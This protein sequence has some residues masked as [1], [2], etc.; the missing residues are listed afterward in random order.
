MGISIMDVA[1]F[2]PSDKALGK[3]CLPDKALALTAASAKLAGQLSPI[4]LATLEQ[5]MRVINSYYSNLIEGN[6]TRP[7]EI[8]AAQSGDYS[9]DSTKRDLQKESLAHMAVQAW[10]SE[11]NPSIDTIFSPEFILNLHQ[12]FYQRVPESL[13]M[14]KDEQGNET[15][16]VI[17]GQWRTRLVEVGRHVSPEADNLPELMGRFCETYH[18]RAYQGDRKLIAMMAAH[19]RFAWIH[20]F[21]DG[22]GRIGR[23]F[24]D[25]AL[26]AIGLD[27]YGAWCLSRGLA[28]SS[29]EYKRLLAAADAP[30][31]GNYD[32]RGALTEK[33]L[34]HFCD[35][36]LDCASDQVSYIGDLLKLADLRKRINAYV[37]A[38]N[39][40]RVPGMTESLKP[41][42]ALVLYT[43]FIHG[44]IERS[45]ALELCAMPDR[46]AR[47]LLS[48]LKK[49]GLLSEASTKSPLRWEIPE[50]A[51][52]WYFPELAPTIS[53]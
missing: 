23:L 12:Q 38:R 24:T 47:R 45:E 3:S 25:A 15:E 27:S 44:E 49:E 17:P 34:L 52:K 7:Y 18:P 43:A 53:R 20:P 1:P 4:T 42:A 14:I 19:H 10:V 51:E 11:Q 41:S 39:D 16:K 36:M 5:H 28:K 8:R 21:L 32:G 46:S 37:Q 50:H 48:Q 40:F 31:Q 33:G 26:R 30:R 6:P 22:N 13:W 35:Y 29:T 9:D 2:L